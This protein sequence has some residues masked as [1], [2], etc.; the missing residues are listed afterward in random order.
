MGL[1]YRCDDRDCPGNGMS[2]PTIAEIRWN[3]WDC[4]TCGKNKH[5]TESERLEH[6]IG[7]VDETVDKLAALQEK[8]DSLVSG[9]NG[10]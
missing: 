8:V 7:Y 1:P 4:K 2:E 9:N 3:T 6:L 10:L 5:M